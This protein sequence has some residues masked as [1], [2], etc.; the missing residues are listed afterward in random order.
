MTDLNKTQADLIAAHTTALDIVQSQIDCT[1]DMIRDARNDNDRD[2]I[3]SIALLNADLVAL[4]R[5]R[6]LISATL[7]A[8]SK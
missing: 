7:S 2:G 1:T 3:Q 8:L 6:D 4:T 5:T